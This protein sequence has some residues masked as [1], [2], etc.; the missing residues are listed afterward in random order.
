MY[1]HIGQFMKRIKPH[2][3]KMAALKCLVCGDIIYSRANHDCHWC[4]CKSLMVDAGPGY[5]RAAGDMNQC[6]SVIV[7][8]KTTLADLYSDWALRIL[9]SLLGNREVHSRKQGP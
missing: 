4:S 9:E 5:G 1:G 2:I 6:K 3:I 8:V 7:E